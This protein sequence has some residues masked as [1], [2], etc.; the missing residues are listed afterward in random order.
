MFTGIIE[1][2]GKLIEVKKEDS[3][4]HFTIASEL[5]GALKV[6]QSLAHNGVCLTVVAITG[7]QYRVTAIAETLKKTSLGSLTVGAGLNLERCVKLDSRL[8]GHIVQGHVDT[9]GVCVLKKEVAGSWEYR[10]KFDPSFAGLVIPKGSICVNGVS[11]TVVDPS[12]D[13]LGIAIIPYTYHHTTFRNLEEG[14]EVNLEF[15]VL[16][17]YILRNLELL[18]S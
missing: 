12:E 15:D 17:K 11:L 14:D 7:D 13:E 6:D 10:I 16:G 4:V 2:V 1:T 3:N 9:K 5:S 8:D 18:K